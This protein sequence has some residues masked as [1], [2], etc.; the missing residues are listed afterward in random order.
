MQLGQFFDQ[1]SYVNHRMRYHES[2]PGHD[3]GCSLR[4][5]PLGAT[6]L[7]QTYSRGLPTVSTKHE[8]NGSWNRVTYNTM[9]VMRVVL[10]MATLVV[11]QIAYLDT[12]K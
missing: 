8:K 11:L 9:K 2:S 7:S 6:Y 12:S 3:Q 5:V 10:R 1:E 4:E